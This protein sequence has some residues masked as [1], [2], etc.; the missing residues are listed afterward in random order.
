MIA[1][2]IGA[3]KAAL[4]AS[5]VSTAGIGDVDK[6][7]YHAMPWAVIFQEVEEKI[8]YNGSK[9]AIETADGQTAIRIKMYDRT[10]TFYVDVV[11]R[12][13]NAAED[14][15]LNTIEKLGTHIYDSHGN[16]VSVDVSGMMPIDPGSLLKH[17]AGVELTL[18][19]SGGIYKDKGYVSVNLADMEIQT[20]QG[21]I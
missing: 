7:K 15:C 12:D 18:L 6:I 9:V 21:V 2:C 17:E 11:A 1:E 10:V 20:E 16:T 8:T 14:I 19:F 3:I 5:G 4:E 13:I